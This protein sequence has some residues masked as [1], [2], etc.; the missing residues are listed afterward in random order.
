MVLPRSTAPRHALP[1]PCQDWHCKLPPTLSNERCVCHATP[2]PAMP[3][4]AAPRLAPAAPCQPRHE[5][6]S[7]L[8]FHLC[9]ESPEFR[10]PSTSSAHSASIV[11]CCHQFIEHDNRFLVFNR[12]PYFPAG[13]NH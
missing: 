13:R 5:K 12:E 8:R 6:N 10:S 11:I 4:L 9:Q 3:Y 1:R 7:F 2:R